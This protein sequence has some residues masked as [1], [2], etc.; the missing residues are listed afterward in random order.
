MFWKVPEASAHDSD[1]KSSRKPRT[2]ASSR[3]FWK[4]LETAGTWLVLLEQTRSCWSVCHSPPASSTATCVCQADWRTR[5]RVRVSGCVN[6]VR[7]GPEGSE[8]VP[9][10]SGNF[11]YKTRNLEE[12]RS[13]RNRSH[14]AGRARSLE[15]LQE[16]SRD[17]VSKRLLPPRDVLD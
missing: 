8:K 2:Y 5:V 3:E 15:L 17:L 6:W 14:P 12:P 13:L 9:E 7:H 11:P 10:C 16:F 4:L 1:T